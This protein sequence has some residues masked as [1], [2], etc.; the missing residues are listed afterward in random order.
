LSVVPE[1]ELV[2]I[3]TIDGDIRC[4][5]SDTD[6]VVEFGESVADVLD[7]I[8]TASPDSHILMVGQLGR[9]DPAFVKQLVAADRPCSQPSPAPHPADSS[10]P[11]VS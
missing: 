4:D 11:P 7:V 3:Q 2:I 10:T 1:P 6:H 9:P 5:G 8:V